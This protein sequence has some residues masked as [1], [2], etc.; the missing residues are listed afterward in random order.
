LENERK[1]FCA[2][3]RPYYKEEQLSALIS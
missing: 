3:V 1:L 2:Q